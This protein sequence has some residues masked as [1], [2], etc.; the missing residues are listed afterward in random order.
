M[1]QLILHSIYLFIAFLSFQII[2]Q[3]NEMKGYRIEGD[4][5]VFTFNKDDY[6]EVS[7]DGFGNRKH[8]DDLTV[9]N[10]VVAGQFNN[11]SKDKWQMKK[12]DNNNYELRKKIKDFTDEFSWE[13]KFVINNEY[14]AEPTSKDPN[15]V[16][17]T[18]EG[19]RLNVYNLKLFSGAYPDKNGNVRFRLK[20]H[21][22]AKK[23]IL[24]GSFNR[25][26]HDLFK[27]Y[28]IENGWEIILNLKPGDYQYRFIVDGNWME[29][30][31]NPDKVENEFGE[32][33]SHIAV[34]KRVDFHLKGYQ[35]A[36][37]VI[38]TGT[39]NNWDEEDCQMEKTNDGWVYSLVLSGGKHHYKFIVDNKWV[40]DPDN[41]VKEY[42]GKGN[43]NSVCMVK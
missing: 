36:E 27:M 34:K 1:K 21:K 17:A 8:F 20:D 4:E 38:L 12:I 14:W 24:S 10:V 35:K 3:N 31:T 18:K 43:I 29:D 2:A 26:N 30:P 13:F 33:N 23:V 28:R 16:G 37:K 19:S 40:F 11:W 39:F 15:I 6:N 22:Q 25:W 32:Y 41:S 42:D 5:I 9:E 7:H